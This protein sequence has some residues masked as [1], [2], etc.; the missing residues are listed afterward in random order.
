MMIV[1]ILTKSSD[2]DLIL[3]VAG[4]VSLKKLHHITT[5]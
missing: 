4:N 1:S 2:C 3:K 5:L